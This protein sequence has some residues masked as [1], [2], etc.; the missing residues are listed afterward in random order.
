MKVQSPLDFSIPTL[1][2]CIKPS[3]FGVWPDGQTLDDDRSSYNTT[4]DDWDDILFFSEDTSLAPILTEDR[5]TDSG[6][7]QR[8][9]MNS[10]KANATETFARQGA[11]PE[12]THPPTSDSCSPDILMQ[13]LQSLSLDS[14]TPSQQNTEDSYAQNSRPAPGYPL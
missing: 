14:S 7:L 12:A 6:Q 2:H 13:E 4:M 10:H 8:D 3:E 5:P 1:L 11:T 9:I